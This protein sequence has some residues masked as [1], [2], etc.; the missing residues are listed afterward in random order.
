MLMHF[1]AGH[2]TLLRGKFQL[3]E[4]PQSDL[5]RQADSRWALPQI[6]S[7]LTNQTNILQACNIYRVRQKKVPPQRFFCFLSNH[8]AF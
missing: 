2:V 1:S 6:S 8:L 3:P 4:S 5:R 7:S